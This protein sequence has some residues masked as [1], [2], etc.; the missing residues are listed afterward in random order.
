MGGGAVLWGRRGQ[1]CGRAGAVLWAGRGQYCGGGGW[2]SI[3]GGAGAVLWGGGSIVGGAVLPYL[4][5]H[6]CPGS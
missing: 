5:I 4:C 2:G 3:V 1:Y 6:T